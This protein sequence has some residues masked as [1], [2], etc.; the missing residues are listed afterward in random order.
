MRA[1][2]MSYPG[3]S[4]ITSLARGPSGVAAAAMA[5][6][7]LPQQAPQQPVVYGLSFELKVLEICLDM[8]RCA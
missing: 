2:V 3:L 8:V 4:R 1:Q 7:A 5:A 6:G